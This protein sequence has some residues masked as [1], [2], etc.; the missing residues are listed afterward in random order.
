MCMYVCI[1]FVHVSIGWTTVFGKTP[2]LAA[3]RSEG[4]LLP[5]RSVEVGEA[6]GAQTQRIQPQPD[7]GC[8]P[9]INLVGVLVFKYFL[10]ILS[11]S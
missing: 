4:V 11:M 7:L 9:S 2:D 5:K 3:L 10:K 8:D 1:M 6:L